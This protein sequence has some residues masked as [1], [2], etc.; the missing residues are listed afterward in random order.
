MKNFDEPL[1][2]SFLDKFETHDEFHSL[3]LKV[4]DESFYVSPSFLAHQ[5]PVFRAMLLTTNGYTEGKD[6]MIE[7]P[8]K[9]AEDIQTLLNVLYH[10][11]EVEGKH[12]LRLEFFLSSKSFSSLSWELNLD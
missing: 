9:K 10:Y 12:F 3:C 1:A 2:N 11:E 6:S 7:L 8:G 4:E 5:S